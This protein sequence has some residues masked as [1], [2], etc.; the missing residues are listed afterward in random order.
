[1]AHNGEMN[2]GLDIG[3][4]SIKAVAIEPTKTGFT[5]LAASDCRLNADST[6]NGLVADYG[7]LVQGIKTITEKGSFPSKYVATA[8][9]G[10]STFARRLSVYSE[11]VSELNE[12]F[13]WIIDQY[14]CLDPEEM[15]LDFEILGEGERYRHIKLLVVGARK[16]TVTDI[17][18]VI[19]SSKMIPRV[20]EPEAMSMA[21]LFRAVS[22]VK[23]GTCLLLHIGYVGSAAVL[24]SDGV[25][26]FS[27]EID[28]GG[29][30]CTDIVMEE[31]GLGRDE[32]ERVK[33]DP[34]SHSDP[35]AARIA[36]MDKFCRPLA[37]Q[38]EKILKLYSYK[39][40]GS[41]YKI[42]LSGGA[43]ETFGLTD[44]LSEKFSVPVEYLDPW[45]VVDMSKE[46]EK[47]VEASGRYAYNVA[48]GLAMNGKVY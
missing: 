27:G 23:T 2:T 41:P 40:G 42:M 37:V 44:A 24:L 12:T 4:N 14:V 25:F 10:P 43:C 30:K 19:E 18:S 7:E 13:P 6:E 9:K 29:R 11:S 5:L 21:R 22:P 35:E 17:V 26:D 31:L 32:A 47:T 1:M 46:L 20:I 15:S 3:A 28:L 48:V 38:A 16:D 36:L 33:K 8:L 39:G 34:G 45:K